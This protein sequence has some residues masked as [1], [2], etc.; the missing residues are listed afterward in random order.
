MVVRQMLD[1]CRDDLDGGVFGDDGRH[2]ELFQDRVRVA[3]RE[4][5]ELE[6]IVSSIASG[7]Y[8]SQAL[9]HVS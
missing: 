7:E 1:I 5:K 2:D 8:S 9:V 6:T 3:E 4:V